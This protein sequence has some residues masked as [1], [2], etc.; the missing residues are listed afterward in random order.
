MNKINI[1]QKI[2]SRR[3]Q[4]IICAIIALSLPLVF[5]IPSG[6]EKSNLT[7]IP[8]IKDNINTF[9]IAIAFILMW[10]PIY[11]IFQYNK[12]FDDETNENSQNK[13]KDK[14]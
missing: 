10:I 1:F 13:P 12:E 11:I 5:T 6:I 2:I 14:K 3:K 4:I 8:I 9:P 7:E